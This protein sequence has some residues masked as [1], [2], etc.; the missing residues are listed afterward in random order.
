VDQLGR[1]AVG[2]LLEPG[3]VTDCY[4]GLK[5]LNSRSARVISTVRRRRMAMWPSV[6]ARWV[7][8][9]PTG[10]SSNAPCGPSR[11]PQADQ[12]VPQLPVVA[13]GGGLIP[14]VEPHYRVQPG[15]AGPQLCGLGVAAADLVGQHQLEEVGVG[16]LLLAGQGEPLG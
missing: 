14:G 10:P 12:F 6:L 7:L 8:P 2:E 13:D 3:R 5:R 9:T 16:Q 15:G 1:N 11:N 4:L